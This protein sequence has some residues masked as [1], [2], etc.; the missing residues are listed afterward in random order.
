MEEDMVSIFWDGE[1][2]LVSGMF[3]DSCHNQFR[4][5]CANI[6][7]KTMELKGSA[8][9]KDESSPHPP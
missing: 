5:I 1:R 4:V 2:N 3:G 7:V 8:R 9:Q 6:K